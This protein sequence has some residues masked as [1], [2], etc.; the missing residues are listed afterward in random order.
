MSKRENAIPT[1]G[2][3]VGG[4]FTDFVLQLPHG[5]MLLHKQPSTPDDPSEAVHDGLHALLCKEPRLRGGRMRI[6]HG[7]TIALNAV[8]QRKVSDIALVV[9]EGSRDMLEIARIRMRIPFNVRASRETPLVPRARVFEV[10]TRIGVNGALLSDAAQDE[11]DALCRKLERS[12]VGAVAITLLNSYLE[13]QPERDLGARIAARLPQLLITCSADVWPE[14]REYERTVAACLNAQVHPLMQRYLDRLGQRVRAAAG[15]KAIIQLSSSSGGTL[16]IESARDRPIDTMLSGP[17]SGVTAAGS[18]CE[19]SG[20]DAAITFDMGGTSADIA[21]IHDGKVEFTTKTHIGDLPLMMPVVSV[22]SIGAGGGSIVSVD[23]YGVIKIGPESAGANPGPV[24][25][26]LGATRPT[27]TDC[28]LVL[29]IID[30]DHFLGGTM[31]LDRDKAVEALSG[32]ADRLGLATPEAA[33]EAALKVATARMAAE[34]YKLLAQRG[35]DPASHV[36]VPFGGAG[37]TH[38]AM[39]AAEAGLGKL[40]VPPAAATFCAL[41]AAMADVRREFVR[42]LGHI[43]ITA[44]GEMLWQNWQILEASAREWLECENVALISHRLIHSLD[45]RYAGQSFSITTE[46]P[47]AVRAACDVAGVAEAFH[48]VHEAIYGFRETD[49][50][51]EAVTQRLSIIGEVPKLD[52]PTLATGQ[53]RPRPNGRRRVFHNGA[54]LEAAIYRR[55]QFGAGSQATGPAVIEQDDTCL[56]LPP[57]WEM[58]TNPLGVLLAVKTQE[59][60]IRHVP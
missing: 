39:L 59:E 6:V 1:I 43:R 48:R 34:L 38:A 26:G 31:R 24:A 11:I 27:V 45:M 52:L 50:L 13:P 40:A 4:T 10:T 15:P 2:I 60:G 32:I 29:G 3:D 17:A 57:G 51:I 9:S 46:I 35:Y 25:Y 12:G 20:F 23:V 53:P 49:A 16:S 8:L 44:L 47:A 54:W 56:W 55:E 33:A 19:R 5:G 41:G 7:T 28:Y 42:G 22:S 18:I 37:P 30:P 21:V 14:V 36:V 58:T